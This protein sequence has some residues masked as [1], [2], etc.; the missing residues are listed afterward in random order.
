[1]NLSEYIMVHSVGISCFGEWNT[2]M[3]SGINYEVCNKI[4]VIRRFYKFVHNW[5]EFSLNDLKKDYPNCQYIIHSYLYDLQKHRIIKYY[6][7]DGCTDELE[8]GAK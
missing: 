3:V 4:K 1:M 7:I 6:T 5:N 2:S 8:R